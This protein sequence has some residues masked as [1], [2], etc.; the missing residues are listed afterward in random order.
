MCEENS[1]IIA[2]NSGFLAIIDGQTASKEAHF[3][4]HNPEIAFQA[5]L[6]TYT[7][8]NFKIFNPFEILN[9]AWRHQASKSFLKIF[10]NRA[11]LAPSWR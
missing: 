10:V 1:E 2:R 7:V 4:A 8:A 6:I 9:A 5:H 11:L 3:E